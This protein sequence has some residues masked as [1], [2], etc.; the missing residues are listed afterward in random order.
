MLAIFPTG[1]LPECELILVAEFQIARHC[2][3]LRGSNAD[4]SS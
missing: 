2:C 3:M 1:F 4:L